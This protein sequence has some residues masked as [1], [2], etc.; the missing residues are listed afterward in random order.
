MHTPFVSPMFASPRLTGFTR[1]A[2]AV[3]LLWA[4]GGCHSSTGATAAGGTR[5]LFIGNSLTDVNDLPQMFAAVA[6]AGGFTVTTGK[7][8]FNDYSLDDHLLRGDAVVE[9]RGGDWDYVVLQQGPSGL[10]SSRTQ[11]IAAT[12]QF[13]GVIATEDARPALYMVW[14]DASRRTA[15]DSVS[16]SYT[17]AADA[18][19]G[20]LFPAG[21]AWVS[22][23]ERKPALRLYDD[24]GLHPSPM[25]SYL[26]ALSIYAVMCDRSPAALP[27]R[28]TGINA[29]LLHAISDAD[30]RI[31]QDAATEVTTGL[32]RKG[33]CAERV[34]SL[35]RTD[36][37]GFSP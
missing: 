30:L 8:V 36:D 6:G 17:Q 7:V 29:I 11:L 2:G 19:N 33:H 21:D 31:L 32:S 23:W 34:A 18:V 20:L 9:I 12:Q 22:A 26:A 3:L 13:A 27:V 14:P 1:L 4:G 35:R 10:P 15:F 25:G 28:P 24:D 5:V 16:M 37:G